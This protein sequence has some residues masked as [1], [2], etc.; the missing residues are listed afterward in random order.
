M[1]GGVSVLVSVC[2]CLLTSVVDIL[3]PILVEPIRKLRAFSYIAETNKGHRRI[4]RYAAPN[5]CSSPMRRVAI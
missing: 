1:F 3:E 5:K 4:M 2:Q